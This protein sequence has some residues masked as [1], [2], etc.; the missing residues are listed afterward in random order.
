MNSEVKYVHVSNDCIFNFC[1]SSILLLRLNE[2]SKEKLVNK[3]AWNQ[4]NPSLRTGSQPGQI[5][6]FGK[7]KTEEFGE[8]IGVWKR[9]QALLNQ[10]LTKKIHKLT[11]LLV[12]E[13]ELLCNLGLVAL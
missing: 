8:K 7:C 9:S 4:F 12:G 10:P 2:P 11:C 3:M 6:K 5:K 1:Q 13:R